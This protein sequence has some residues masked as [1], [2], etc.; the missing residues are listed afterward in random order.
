MSD[1]APFDSILVAR[2]AWRSLWRQRRRTLITVSSIGLGL[3][4]AILFIATGEGI[5]DQ[6]IND[7]V[8]MHAGHVTVE[9]PD[10]RV[11][12]SVDLWIRVRPEQRRAIDQMSEVVSSKALLLGQGVAKSGAGAV[13][14]GLMGVEPR[15]ER[16]TSPLARKIVS[17][18]YLSDTDSN[19]V[20]I[21]SRL[22]E[23]LR[24]KPGKKLVIS[25]NNA[26]GELVEELF[27]VKG[28]FTT[29]SEEIDGYLLQMP[30]D[31]ARRLYRLPA[32]AA[33]Q[34]GV[35]LV[36]QA[37]MDSILER[38]RLLFPGAA[39][40]RPWQEILP[41]VAAYIRLDR[42]SN[43][44]FQALLLVIILFTIFNTLLMSAVER[45][46]EFAV[47]LALGTPPVQLRSQLLV[48]AVF[49]AAMGC[50][51]G[52]LVGSLAAGALQQWGLDLT[53]LLPDGIT[54]SGLAVSTRIHARLSVPLL[55]W[56][57]GLVGAATL[58]LSAVPMRRISGHES[59]RHSVPPPECAT[60]VR[61]GAERWDPAE[62]GA[63]GSSTDCF[64][65][66]ETEI[67][68]GV[69][70][71][72]GLGAGVVCSGF[73]HLGRYRRG[74]R[75]GWQSSLVSVPAGRQS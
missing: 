69:H 36:E 6:V 65:T 38:L 63:R 13:G 9:H 35:V 49:L 27:R 19:R 45:E 8:R 28:V 53:F 33:T 26:V 41:E 58:V 29:G 20:V 74:V 15:V 48:E 4:V 71:P 3:A 59:W 51:A 1:S 40:V 46:H 57:A 67:P 39:S 64:G 47:F 34:L 66:A 56:V 23:R 21:G 54:I 75:L 17:G 70:G 43:W 2:L 30:I 12:P 62:S 11:A 50:A 10:Y 55:L 44:V 14:I 18:S 68:S 7:G 25:T 31:S 32:D 61:R 72:V 60:V 5:Y 16:A 42:T 73:G 52:T 24:L 22:A 37:A